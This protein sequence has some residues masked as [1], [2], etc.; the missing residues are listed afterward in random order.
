MERHF[1]LNKFEQNYPFLERIEK[2]GQIIY[3]CNLWK[4]GIIHNMG[5]L[6]D[7]MA[8]LAQALEFFY[9]DGRIYRVRTDKDKIIIEN[10][11]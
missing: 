11:F 10:Q 6:T 1:D 7:L 9:W 2:Q 4:V 5:E 3:I 8:K